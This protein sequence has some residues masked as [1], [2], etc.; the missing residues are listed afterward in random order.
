[1]VENESKMFQGGGGKRIQQ[2]QNEKTP[3]MTP[4]PFPPTLFPPP[5]PS[6]PG[7]EEREQL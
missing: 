1:M 2:P 7:L 5:I 4:L 3:S 6:S